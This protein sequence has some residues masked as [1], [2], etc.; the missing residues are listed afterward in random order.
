[1]ILKR[2]LWVIIPLMILKTTRIQHRS[3][4]ALRTELNLGNNKYSDTLNLHVVA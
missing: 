1:M 2:Y 4:F 3:Y